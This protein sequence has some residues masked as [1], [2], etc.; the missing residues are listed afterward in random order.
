MTATV[1]MWCIV[2]DGNLLMVLANHF[3]RFRAWS[4][5]ELRVYVVASEKDNTINLRKEVKRFVYD[6]RINAQVEVVELN[7]AD[8]S[9]YT[10]QQTTNFKHEEEILK[11]MNLRTVDTKCDFQVILDKHPDESRIYI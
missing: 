7:Q 11:D 5:C 1:D 6:L 4:K 3:I 2:H 8:I 10:S 9:A